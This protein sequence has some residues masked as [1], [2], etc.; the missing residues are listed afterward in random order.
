MW[1][2]IVIGTICAIAA[3]VMSV[4]AVGSISWQSRTRELNDQLAAARYSSGTAVR[5]P[6]QSLPEPVRVYL[7]TVLDSRGSAI[8]AARIEHG[9]TFNMGTA[10]DQWRSFKSEQ[11]VVIDR[12]GFVWNAKI[13]MA[14]L[15]SARVHDAYVAGF[16]E[17]NARVQGLI[18]VMEQPHS[19]ELASG[20]LM[21]FLA[22]SVWYPSALLPGHG[23][24]WYP[25][26]GTR[27]RATITDGATTVSLDFHFGSDGFVSSVHSDGRYRSVDGV[28]I[29][30]PWVGRFWN[31]QERDGV[32]IPLD[33]EV[34]WILPDGEKPYWR[35]HI[36]QIEYETGQQDG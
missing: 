32:I 29:A 12:P 9:G 19:P 33:G 10:D 25:L 34:S 5:G 15:L 4:S 6:D 17:L 13:R 1:W 16:A 7:S 3:V 21:R 20:E 2:K 27:A 30:T 36:E 11:Q 31:Y 18:P 24:V 28:Q 22:E 23:M 14:P 26:D 8:A 35:G